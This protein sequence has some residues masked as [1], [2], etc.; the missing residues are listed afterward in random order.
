[1]AIVQNTL[2]GKASGSVGGTTFTSW[3]GKNVLKSKPAQVANPRTAAQTAQ[4]TKFIGAVASYRQMAPVVQQGF[5]G[6]AVGK[7]AY[8]A[9]ASENIKNGSLSSDVVNMFDD[10]TKLKVA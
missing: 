9:Y 6:L 2:I 5:A 1:M 3:K 4:R 8:N 7:S 10:L